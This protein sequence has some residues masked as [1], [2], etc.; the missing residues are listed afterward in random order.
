VRRTCGALLLALLLPWTPALA[1]DARSVVA[2]YVARLAGTTIEDLTVSQAFTL[3]HPDGRHP[4]VTGSQRLFLKPPRAQRLEQTVDD[5]REVRVTVGDRVWVR[6]PDGRTFEGPPTDGR[7][8]RVHLLTAFQRSADDLLREWQT[9]GVRGDVSDE[10]RMGG[11]S[12]TIIGARASDRDRPAVWI[13]PEHGVV[14]FITRE[15]L[16]QG[17]ALV[18]VV[19]SD[20]R[21]LIDRVFYPYRQE[22]FADGRLL[23]RV[24]VRSVTVNSRLSDDLF[25]PD[26]LK[27]KG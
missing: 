22:V 14:R 9:F 10:T 16:P 4:A 21:P 7:R 3:Y 17:Q 2:A 19:F 8:D 20:H 26:V 27:R 12:V 13:D 6:Q 5:Q 18:D 11:R 1:A 15:R 25:D 23:V 24:S